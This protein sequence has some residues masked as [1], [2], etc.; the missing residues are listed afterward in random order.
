MYLHL[1]DVG[2]AA[3]HG[4]IAPSFSYLGLTQHRS[5]RPDP[6]GPGRSA[7]ISFAQKDGFLD[8][9]VC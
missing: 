4:G 2:V 9:I 8:F 6:A 7:S 5:I 3:S 1:H